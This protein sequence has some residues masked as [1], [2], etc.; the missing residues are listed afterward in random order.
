MEIGK[1]EDSIVLCVRKVTRLM[2][3]WSKSVVLFHKIDQK[4]MNI[5]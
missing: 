5:F 2:K 3:G 4:K 1:R